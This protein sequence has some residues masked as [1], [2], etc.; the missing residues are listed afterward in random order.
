MATPPS[1]AIISDP[2]Q[3]VAAP[4]FAGKLTLGE[5]GSAAGSLEAVLFAPLA[6]QS[7]D[8]TALP[9]L[10]VQV[11]PS[12]NST[13]GSQYATNNVSHAGLCPNASLITGD[14]SLG[15]LYFTLA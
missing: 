14:N 2:L 11:S 15:L 9:A 12:F 6:P 4:G 5:L 13:D 10:P 8:M 3:A 7:L 1:A